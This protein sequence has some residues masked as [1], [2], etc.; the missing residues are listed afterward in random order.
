MSP[1]V[2]YIALSGGSLFLGG[3]VWRLVEEQDYRKSRFWALAGLVV[4]LWAT[5]YVLDQVTQ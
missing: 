5:L 3:Y 1:I 4:L 2:Y